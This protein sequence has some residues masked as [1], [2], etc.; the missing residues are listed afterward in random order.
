[1]DGV[2]AA[3]YGFRS[4][5]GIVVEER[6]A[7]SH[8]VDEGLNAYPFSGMLVIFASDGQANSVPFGYNDACGPDLH[9]EIVDLFRCE[10]VSPIMSMI[11]TVLGTDGRIEFTMGCPEPPLSDGCMG[12]QCALKDDLCS[13]GIKN[14]KDQE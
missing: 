14:T 7:S 5:I 2:L 11:G 9:I 3:K 13:I 8:L 12:I 1:M 6:A 4:V 10:G